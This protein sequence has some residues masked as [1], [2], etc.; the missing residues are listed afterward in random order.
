MPLLSHY[1][2]VL[3]WLYISGC[4]FWLLVLALIYISAPDIERKDWFTL[5]LCT[6]LSWAALLLLYRE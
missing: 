6:P 2:N 1:L 3:L 5:W 4:L